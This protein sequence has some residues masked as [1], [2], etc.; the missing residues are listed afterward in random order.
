MKSYKIIEKFNLIYSEELKGFFLIVN[1]IFYSEFYIDRVYVNEVYINDGMVVLE[2][3]LKYFKEEKF[4]VL[5]K[6][7]NYPYLIRRGSFND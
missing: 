5:F 1:N 3:L 6:L 4:F 2:L 7:S